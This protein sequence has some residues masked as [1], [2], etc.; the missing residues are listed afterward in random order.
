MP[1]KL[2]SNLLTRIILRSARMPFLYLLVG[3][4]LIALT[5]IDD[6]FP[7]VA[8]KHAFDFT[9]KAGNIL[10]VFAFIIFFYNLF[11]FLMLRYEQILAE[12]QHKIASLIIGS[13]RKNSR[14]ILILVLLNVLFN[15]FEPTKSYLIF[16]N[17]FVNTVL[18]LAIGW[19]AIQIFH[20]IEAV[21]LQYM[22]T[23]SREEH[24]RVK[25]IY[26]KMHIIRNI[27]TVLIFI[28]TIAAILMSFSS[29]R[30]IGISLLASAGFMTAIIGLA[31]QRTL[32]SLFSG[33]QIAL[34]Q[35]IKIGDMVVIE[36]ES[37]IIEEIT[38]TYVTL[39][40]GDRRRLIVP[41][42][43]FIEKPF[44]NWSHDGHSMRSSF[45]FH[46]DY[47]MP[48][49]PLR[50][51][52]DRILE[53]SIYWDGQAK[54]MEVSNLTERTV[55]LRVQ[56]SAE[57]ADNLADLRAEV[58]EKILEFIRHHHAEHLPKVRLD[59]DNAKP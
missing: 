12:Q 4:L 28:I 45:H 21:I 46:I 42:N 43:F 57:N 8:W 24:I 54:K 17:N 51:E 55:E 1:S 16:A 39:K 18:I 29:V 32:F 34:G 20:T 27:A 50:Q 36:K 14:V 10:V 6:I 38:L 48:I 37:G 47:L 31:A 23:L 2:K 15:I 7:L 52:L 49:E 9:D 25:G 3:I 30:N 5:Y 35:P 44:E 11:I 40:L 22:N 41:I 53:H 13:V 19:I 58:R 56:I 33:F 26:T 59:G